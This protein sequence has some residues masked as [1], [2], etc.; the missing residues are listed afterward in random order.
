MTRAVAVDFHPAFSALSEKLRGFRSEIDFYVDRQ[1]FDISMMKSGREGAL[2]FVILLSPRDTGAQAN[3]VRVVFAAVGDDQV[4]VAVRG[5]AGGTN[6]GTYMLADLV[7][8]S[9]RDLVLSAIA[10]AIDPVGSITASRARL[11]LW[12]QEYTLFD[13]LG[14]PFAVWR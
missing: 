12:L 7:G 1:G 8:P 13:R 3:D 6:L 14:R 10:E 5:P 11:L 2:Q 9:L 4:S